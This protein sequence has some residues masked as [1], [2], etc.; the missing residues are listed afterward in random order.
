MKWRIVLHILG[1][2]SLITAAALIPSLCFAVYESGEAEIGWRTTKAFGSSIVFC[3]IL[4]FGLWYGTRKYRDDRFT[5]SEGFAVAALGWALMAGLGAMP[6][7]LCANHDIRAPGYEYKLVGQSPGPDFT[8]IDAYFECISG[9]T[10]TGSSVFGTA[11]DPKTGRGIG[12]IEALPKSF[13]F[14]RSLTHWLGGMGI[15]VLCLALLP[16]LRAGGYQMFQAEVPGPTADRLLPRVRQTAAILW[17]VYVLLSGAEALLLWLGDMPLFDALCHTF[18]TM[19]TGGFSTKD[20]SIGHYFKNGVANNLYFEV[21]IDVF[22]FLAGVNFLLHFQ[23]LRGNLDAYRK[24]S[25]FRF[26]CV[27]VMVAVLLLTISLRLSGMGPDSYGQTLR[28]AVFQTLA[29]MTTTGFATA[30]FDLWPGFC[31]LLLVVLMFFGGCAGSTG[32]GLK[33]IRIYVIFKY[34]YRSLLRLLRPGLANRI[35]VGEETLDE[36]LVANIIGLA[37]LWA[38]VFGVACVL[39]MPLLGDTM[40]N[41]NWRLVTAV[42]AVAATLNNIGPGLAGVGATCNFGWMPLSAKVLLSICMLMGRLEIYSV[43]VVLL[44]LTWR[45]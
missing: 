43:V 20:A 17:G 7:Y 32:G 11:R 19:A 2:L 33:Q 6:M 9:F 42:T 36:K 45:K 26:Y 12:I 41:E 39:L 40:Q 25:E 38:V 35:R 44:P 23:A 15:V 30:N 21:V 22:M 16:A 14:W 4:G 1:A 27:V 34:I 3:T 18:G 8:Y 10:T 28:E 13:L 24:N 31:R 37:L 29:I 5:A